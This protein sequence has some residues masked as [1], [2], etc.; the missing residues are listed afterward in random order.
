MYECTNPIRH[1]PQGAIV[2]MNVYEARNL[3]YVTY[4]NRTIIL[5]PTIFL[6]H[7][8]EVE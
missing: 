4:R 5:K 2:E 1:I 7:F 8:K 3:C 6:S